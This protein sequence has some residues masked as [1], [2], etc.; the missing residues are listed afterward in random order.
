M[1]CGNSSVGRAQ[2]C[3]GWGREFES[4][5]PLW[6]SATYRNEVADFLFTCG[7]KEAKEP[8]QGPGSHC[9]SIKLSIGNMFSLLRQ[10]MRNNDFRT[11]TPARIRPRYAPCVPGTN[12]GNR[13]Q[14]NN[15]SVLR[16]HATPRPARVERIGIKTSGSREF[17]WP[18]V[19]K[20]V[21]LQCFANEIIKPCC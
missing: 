14:R 7:G 12:V 4:R 15:L 18:F 3:Q 13:K 20:R 21:Y 19:G 5:F 9:L 8:F 6:E 2:P 11:N 1:P 16:A 17:F 10:T